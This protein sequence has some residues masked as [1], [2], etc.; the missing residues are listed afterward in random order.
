MLNSISPG[1]GLFEIPDKGSSYKCR[2]INYCRNRSVNFRLYGFILGFQ[3]NKRNFHH[4]INYFFGIN[5][6]G[7]PAYI[8]GSVISFVI[9][10]PA[11]ITTLLQILTGR[12]VAFDPIETW[13]PIRVSFHL[14]LSPP[15]GPPVEKLSFINF[16]PW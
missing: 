13:L 1:K 6:A 10:A 3:I 16:T 11:P 7:F 15:A 4:L 12:T 5:R 8:P 2:L 14:F 9:T